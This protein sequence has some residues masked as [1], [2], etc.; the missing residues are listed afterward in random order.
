M[1]LDNQSR[2]RRALR[3]IRAHKNNDKGHIYNF[4]V[5]DVLTDLRH[6]CEARGF[7]F[8]DLDRQSYDHYIEESRRLSNA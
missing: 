5:V 3:A 4:D 2:R 7:D 8:S 1:T 6:Y